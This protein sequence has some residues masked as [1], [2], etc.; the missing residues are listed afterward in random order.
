MAVRIVFLGKLVDLAHVS[1]AMMP[2]SVTSGWEALRH[3]IEESFGAELARAVSEDSVKI[4]LNG[5]LVS[6]R[7]GL[8]VKSGD[9]LALLP[10][11]SGG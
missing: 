1:E 11:V 5:H 10:P 8:Q 2:A 4:A 9:E 6:S 7:D 3:W